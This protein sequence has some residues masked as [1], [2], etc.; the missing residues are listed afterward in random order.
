MRQRFDKYA[1]PPGMQGL[2]W[3]GQKF[4]LTYSLTVAANVGSEHYSLLLTPRAVTRKASTSAGAVSNA[5]T[6]RTQFPCGPSQ[7]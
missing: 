3:P 6:S 5:V 1:H 2:F 4:F 7:R